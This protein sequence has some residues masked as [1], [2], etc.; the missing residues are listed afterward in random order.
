[1]VIN[2]QKFWLILFNLNHENFKAWTKKLADKLKREEQKEQ[3]RLKELQMSIPT[4][5]LFFM[6]L[7]NIPSSRR[8]FFFSFSYQHFQVNN[9]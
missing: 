7:I 6:K 9:F 4:E 3:K 5:K 2:N 1:M 8:I